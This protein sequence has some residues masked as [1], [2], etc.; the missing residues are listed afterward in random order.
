MPALLVGAV[1]A[2]WRSVL[3]GSDVPLF[4]NIL[5]LFH[6]LIHLST[7]A[8]MQGSL[9]WWNPYSFCGTPLAADPQAGLFS[10][11]NLPYR[12]FG[13]SAAFRMQLAL[14]LALTAV[15]TNALARRL[16]LSRAG[17]L[18]AGLLSA[19]NGFMFY[20][21]GMI[22]HLASLIAMPATLLFW[23][24]G[25]G[26]LAGVS[27]S[28]Q[29]LGGHPFF[30]YITL[31]A[32]LF[33]RPRQALMATAGR[34][35]A[36]AIIVC[37]GPLVGA[38]K[39]FS[40]TDAT[41]GMSE[42]S[43]YV[44]SLTPDE[45]WSQLGPLWNRFPENFVEDYMVTSFYIGLPAALL[46]FW[47][48]LQ[49]R[50][51]LLAMSLAGLWLA[52]GDK[53]PFYPL[54]LKVSPGIGLFRYPA[55][56]L[57][58]SALALSLLAGSGLSRAGPR[59]GM[60]LALLAATD[61]Y[62]FTSRPPFLRVA[63]GYY[64][65]PPVAAPPTDSRV[66]H[67]REFF[68]SPPSGE[69]LERWTRLKDALAPLHASV[70]HVRETLSYNRYRPPRLEAL[71]ASEPGAPLLKFVGV[72]AGERQSWVPKSRRMDWPDALDHLRSK[73]FDPAAEVILE[74][75]PERLG[76]GVGRVLSATESSQRFLADVESDSD[77]YLVRAERYDQGW[78]AFIDGQTAEVLRANGDFMAVSL[79]AGRH[80]VV[81]LYRQASMEAALLAGCA[82]LFLLAAAAYSRVRMS[83]AFSPKD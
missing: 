80:Q 31:F 55:Q 22:P 49:H 53:S 10:P 76:A 18:L 38:Y 48:A 73:R 32:C 54:L 61:V 70:F 36:T 67:G 23:I 78:S 16:G 46:A 2:A 30:V 75:A 1:W 15:F 40:S 26:A 62:L 51:A 64:S 5:F 12:F 9:P 6:P 43:L 3:W 8:L 37:L 79:P 69:G 82:A 83:T 45:L 58:L 52:L 41:R 65:L 72:A 28:L 35:A 74:D 20:H 71:F 81:W 17:S 59:A 14:S 60:I 47:G 24:T 19:C 63:D 34:T 57:C 56:W 11:L 39:L 25:R 68:N 33:L 44:F 27:L 21:G 50:G 4:G 7:E 77:G 29:F 66:Y 13:W 42:A